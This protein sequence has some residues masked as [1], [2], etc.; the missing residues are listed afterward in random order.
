MWGICKYSLSSLQIL[1]NGSIILPSSPLPPFPSPSRTQDPR[2]P[3]RHLNGA[4]SLMIPRYG[5]DG[6]CRNLPSL[7]YFKQTDLLRI[8]P[9]YYL[10]SFALCH[11]KKR[12]AA[13]KIRDS[14]RR[15]GKCCC[16]RAIT[17]TLLISSLCLQEIWKGAIL[18]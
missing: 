4:D 8:T 17:S 18:K 1:E 14:A 13:R 3:F 15:A 10:S 9:S 2:P 16:K 6:H 7:T 11:L 12:F 5:W